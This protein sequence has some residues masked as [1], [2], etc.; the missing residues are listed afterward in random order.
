ME[1]QK[2]I[3]RCFG[4]ILTS[5]RGEGS[6]V[7]RKCIPLRSRRVLST[8]LLG[9]GICTYGPAIGGVIAFLPPMAFRVCFRYTVMMLPWNKTHVL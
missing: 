6:F 3:C 2:V 8:V 5:S 7:S 1:R 4:V 9:L